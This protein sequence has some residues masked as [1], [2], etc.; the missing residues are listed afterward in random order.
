MAIKRIQVNSSEEESFK[1]IQKEVEFLKDLKHLNIVAYYG[2]E[3]QG[4]YLKIYLEYID[5]GS[6][7][8]M[9]K[10]YGPFPQDIVIHYTK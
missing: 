1:E 3:I 7:A 4:E 5:M 9:L 2:S 10:T 8:S 6:I